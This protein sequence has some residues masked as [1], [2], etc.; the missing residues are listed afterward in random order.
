MDLSRRSL[1]KSAIAF[2]LFSG[3]GL[4]ACSSGTSGIGTASSGGSGTAAAGTLALNNANWSHDADNDV[5]Y[6][7]GLSYVASPAAP[8][9]E[10]LGIY[11]PGAYFTGTDNGDGTHKVAINTSGSVNGFTPA[12][13]PIVLPVNTQATPPRNHPPSTPTIRSRTTWQ[14]VS[15]TSMQA[16]AARTRTPTP[17]PATPPGGHR[18]QGGGALPA[19]QLGLVAGRDGQDVRVRAQRR[20]RAELRDGRLR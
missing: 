15:S 1:F 6:Q 12:T 3:F 5:Y 17:T 20:R 14:P 16:C 18:S 2:T 8:D 19:L 9:Y 10:T 7:I 11:V 4:A 13:A